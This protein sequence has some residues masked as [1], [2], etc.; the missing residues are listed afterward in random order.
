M[1]YN[2]N[3]HFTRARRVFK[4]TTHRKGNLS[5][6][7]DKWGENLYGGI[8]LHSPYL[9]FFTKKY[10]VASAFAD[11]KRLNYIVETGYGKE[12]VDEIDGLIQSLFVRLDSMRQQE[13]EAFTAASAAKRVKAIEVMK[14]AKIIT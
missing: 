1:L 5:I 7:L 2:M 12:I 10:K 8:Y 11:W 14:K 3:G 13:G 4:E 9:I 6:S